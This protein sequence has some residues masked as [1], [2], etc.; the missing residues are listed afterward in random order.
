MCGPV[1]AFTREEVEKAIK[2]MKMGKAAESSGITAEFWK[3]LG[4]EESLWMCK[5]LNRITMEGKIP[6]QWKDSKIV[7][8]YKEKGDPMDCATYRDIKLLE[9]GPQI[10]EKIL[11]KRLREIIVIDKM[12]FGFSKGTDT[13]DGIFTI[14]QVQ[15][16][17]REKNK[18]VFMASLDLEIAYDRVPRK[19]VYW[20]LRKRGVIEGLIK[21]VEETHNGAMTRIR[22]QCG[23]T[24][25][26]GINVG[27]HQGSALSPFL[28]IAIM[29]T[30]TSEI[31][32][33]IPWELIF[34]DDIALVVTT[35]EELQEKVIRWQEVLRK[36]G[37][38]MNAENSEVMICEK[39][40]NTEIK[41]TDQGESELKQVQKFKYLGS[42][43]ATEGGSLMTVKQRITAAWSK[44][45]E[46]TG[47][48]C[49]KTLPR[50]LKCNGG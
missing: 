38:K 28:F 2:A 43:I 24:E 35:E 27:V 50:K 34:S 12:Q 9:H 29:D 25:A 15:E 31:R 11:D 20:C 39:N 8:I 48:I 36:G 46:V 45:R 32:K 1:E 40:G 3:N 21:I 18:K 41:V 44:W 30:L 26:F 13:T 5:L 14:R 10:I 17:M 6:E 23:N 42:E 7:T 22:T 16:K 4:E 19:V 37:L 49:D 47:I 33:T